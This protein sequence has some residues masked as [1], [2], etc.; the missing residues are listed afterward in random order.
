MISAVV[1]AAGEAKR[2]RQPKLLMPFGRTTIIESTLDN[3]LASGVDEIVLVLGAEAEKIR[4]AAGARPIRPVVNNAYRDGMATSIVAGVRAASP[5][6]EWLMIAL[7]DQ[8]LIEPETYR[9]IIA[10]CTDCDKGIV[11]PVH[12][13]RRGNPVVFFHTYRDELLKLTGDV[14]GRE[15]VAQHSG[16]VREVT[17]DSAGV[18]TD[19]DDQVDYSRYSR[20][21]NGRMQC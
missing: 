17:V 9:S 12:E 4:L 6:A 7:G 1:L 5:G 3:L 15:V 21:R 14:G 18:L 13:G 8:P 2:M 20:S 19:I 10:A 16:D 11:L